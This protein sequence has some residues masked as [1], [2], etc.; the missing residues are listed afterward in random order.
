MGQDQ[1][2]EMEAGSLNELSDAP[3]SLFAKQNQLKP[4]V[5]EVS[6]RR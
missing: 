5:E 4:V 6:S 3:K 1:S 2:G